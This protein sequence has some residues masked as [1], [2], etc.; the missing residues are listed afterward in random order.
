MTGVQTCALPIWQLQG[1]TT[2]KT[3]TARHAFVTTDD[4]SDP[5]IRVRA[6]RVKIVPGKYIEMWNAVLFMDGVPTFYFPYYR[7]E[8]G[9]RANNFN[10]LPGYRS[11]YGPFLLNTY[12]WFL[13]DTVDGKIH[14]D[15]R[16][17]RGVGAGPDLKLHLGQWGEAEF[18]YYYLQDRNPTTSTNGT[19]WIDEFPKT[20]SAFTSAT[21]RQIGRAHV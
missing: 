11:A 16:E 2:N 10:F 3:Y 5:A 15:Y 8:L 6:S 9:L 14:L 19:P 4:V 7:R 1:D 18:K 21:R 12:T 17:K 20:A 13:N